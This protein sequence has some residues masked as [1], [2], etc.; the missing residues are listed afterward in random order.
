M[1]TLKYQIYPTKSQQ[2]F[3]WNQSNL[4]NRLY[5]QFLEQKI[6]AYKENGINIKRFDLQKQLVKIKKQNSEYAKIHSQVLQQV[7]K[8]LHET[9]TAFFNRGF[10]FPNF[11]S[12][13]FF[14]GLVFPQDTGCRFK[15][16]KLV[17]G[18]QK[19][20]VLLHKPLPDKI[21]T[22]T[23]TRST[24]NKWFVC[25][26]YETEN[27]QKESNG[28]I[29]GVDLGLKNIVYCS[30]GHSILNK[31]HTKY[32]DRQ[33]AKLQSKQTKHKK[34]SKQFRQFAR[35]INRL[36]GLK[37]RKTTDFLHKV[38][39]TLASKDFDII[40]LEK[41]EP[42][43]MSEGNKTG[44][45]KSI[46]NTQFGK[47]TAFLKYK[48]EALGKK[49]VFVNPKNTSKKCCVCGKKHNMPLSNRQMVCDCGNNV[50]RDFNASINIMNLARDSLC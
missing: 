37:A 17:V 42:K 46:R 44:L 40:G 36:Y 15:N 5:N 39:H 18:E 19:I 32:F 28:K 26:T 25:I 3:L 11:R 41:L 21:K 14:F 45:N 30:D 10:G 16:K 8:R 35:T 24:D 27:A 7:P 33:I 50:D 20:K 4:L 9:F 38:S 49:I 6:K 2:A 34:G 47:L 22:K 31:N 1:R 48:A 29:L 23:I 13:R 12:S 43:R